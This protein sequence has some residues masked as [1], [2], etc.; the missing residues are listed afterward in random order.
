MYAV[1]KH[2]PERVDNEKIV[3]TKI[4]ET[5]FVSFDQIFKKKFSIEKSWKKLLFESDVFIYGL[6]VYKCD[7][8]S[9]F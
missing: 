1:Y 2:G 6:N 3:P 7:L 5:S 4:G 8:C 9:I